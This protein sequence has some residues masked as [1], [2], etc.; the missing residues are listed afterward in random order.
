MIQGTY[1]IFMRIAE[2]RFGGDL[3]GRF[4]LTAGLGGMGGAQPL[5]G[6]MAGA[7][8][9]CVDIDPERAKKRRE[10]GYLQ[11]IAPDLDTALA[12]IDA[13][14][15]DKRALSVGPRRQCRRDLPGNRPARHRARR[16]HRPDLGARS[17]LRLRAEGHDASIR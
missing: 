3:S 5:A 13:A 4:V 14:V 16:R 10:I 2:R 15:Q 6:R 1:E 7:A 12:M 17:G 8:I 9:L 11:E